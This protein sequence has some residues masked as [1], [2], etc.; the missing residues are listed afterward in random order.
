MGGPRGA[1]AHRKTAVQ[2]QSVDV[3][4]P[5]P[6]DLLGFLHALPSEIPSETTSHDATTEDVEPPKKRARVERIDAILIARDSFTISRPTQPEVSTTDPISRPNVHH[7]MKLHYNQN[8]HVL[9]LS[10]TPRSPYGAFKSEISIPGAKF[11]KELSLILDVLKR[12]RDDEGEEGALWVSIA[13]DLETKDSKDKLQLTLGL[14]WNSSTNIFRTPSQRA[15]SQQVLD[16]FFGCQTQ[17]LDT[18]DGKLLPQAF[19]DA[20][21][22]TEKGNT[23]MSITPPRLT[24]SL[25][26]FQRRALQWLLNREGVKWSGCANG[27]PVL[28][29]LPPPS[30]TGLP[31]SF[32]ATKDMT[33]QLAFVSNLYHV[34]TRDTAPFRTIE[35]TVKG[36]ILAEEMGL[37]KTVEMISLICTHTR[38]NLPGPSNGVAQNPRPS[39][40]TLIVTPS[41]LRDQW[42]GEFAKHAPDLRVMVYSGLR[43]FSGD[44]DDLVSELASQDVVVTTYDVLQSEI[45][46]TEKPPNRSMR[47]APKY[48]RPKSPLVHIS[49]WRVC[50]D[51]AQQIESGVSSAAKV[52]RLIPRVNAW[53][54]TG[55]PVK[56]DIKDLWGLL[57]FLHYEPFASSTAVWDMLI[58]SHKEFF[59]PLF[60]RIALRHTKRAVRD[61][62]TLPPQK[63]YV[64][65]IPFTA[66]EEEHYQA[67]F[68]ELTKE[69][70]FD[71]RGVL[72]QGRAGLDDPKT[73]EMMK[74]ALASLRLSILHPSLGPGLRRVGWKNRPLHT[75]EEMLETMIEQLESAIKVDQRTYLLEMIK[76]GQLLEDLESAIKLWQQ[77]I[78][79]VEVL[80]DECRKQVV[81]ALEKARQAG[82]DENL[83]ESEDDEDVNKSKTARQLS[84]YRRRLRW[85]LDVQHRAVF[86]MASAYYELKS[87][88]N[89]TAPDSNEFK[90]LEEKEV[91]GYATAKNIRKEMLQE[92]HT[93]VTSCISKLRGKAESQSFTVIPPIELPP[94][95]GIESG[96]IV[97]NFLIL[98]QTLEHQA[99]AIDQYREAVIQM[100]IRPLVDE[101]G[102]EDVTGDEYED[103]TKLQDELMAYTLA[104]RALVTDRQD[105]ISGLDNERTRHEVAIAEARAKNNEGHAPKLTL[106]LLAE[107]SKIKQ[108][109][110]LTSFRSI[111]ADLRDLAAR[112]RSNGGSDR[113][114]IELHIVEQHLRLTQ[115]QS[116]AQSKTAVGLL[117]E[118]DAFTAALNARVEYYRQLQSISDTLVPLDPESIVNRDTMILASLQVEQYRR[119]KVARDLPKHRYLVH[120]KE[121]GQKQEEECIICQSSF[122][123]GVLTV[124][125]HQFCK[126]CIRI[127]LRGRNTCPVCKTFLAAGMTYDITLKKQELKVH[128]EHH[129]NSREH[130]HGSHEAGSPSKRR[131]SGIY[132]EI[133]SQ[134]LQAIKNI[135]VGAPS[136]ATKVN[137]LA[138]HLLWLRA[139]D[140][141]AK[142]IIFSQ[143][144]RFLEILG[145]A[146]DE[147]RI[148]YTSF[149]QKNGITKFKEE[150]GIECFLM[151]ARAH[152]SGLNLINASHVFLCEPVLN[153]ALELQAIARVD[154]IGQVHPTTVWLYLI[155]GTVEESIYNLSVQ[156]R[157]KYIGKDSKGKSK[158][159]TDEITDEITDLSIEEANSMVVEQAS[160]SKLMNKDQSLG[161]AID[162]DDLWQCFFG[163]VAKQDTQPN[164]AVDERMNDP[165]VM[166]FLA[167]EAAEARRQGE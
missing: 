57:V 40:A 48:H 164:A 119:G 72:M 113:A 60:N 70:G 50:L 152:A 26:P 150:P 132:S 166:G 100:L 147:Y 114:R 121:A 5:F 3:K 107:R 125:G 97:N 96:R 24:S 62:L 21:F 151:D 15:L 115:D 36:G 159:S 95:S 2:V 112:L 1:K 157:L 122:T 93:K 137:T 25:F 74:H 134:K 92:T 131:K 31:L 142:S 39:G 120:L 71:E 143:F 153:T 6:A 75:V 10:S 18:A 42:V 123:L 103:S 104:L 28:E 84:E 27:E 47:N 88:E 144:P 35:T 33:G 91:S 130:P 133:D 55:T 19:Y 124:C 22:L 59:Q 49:W 53:G 64:I 89:K 86:F 81:D 23:D 63:R 43:G 82:S 109:I 34:M 102:N 105:A 44:E 163:H 135:D 117:K 78:D 141:G 65:T 146:F 101:E 154:R 110:R 41:T 99:K 162:K 138:K 128:Q 79:E 111:I 69:C 148:G 106:K 77:I 66:V 156:R 32:R 9:V 136:Y 80:V 29:P 83:E 108:S 11:T 73:I 87:D 16:V 30:T 37:G 14:N 139:Q 58:T 126:D 160:L 167:G 90:A 51:E 38:R 161:E 140:P 155:D 116:T 61:E 145:Q 67:Q 98:E 52:A 85:M 118:L 20:A 17:V 158:Q 8:H 76:R 45:H 127:W 4:A 54:V 56:G 13:V 12:S 149:R 68:T 94:F 46:Y 7:H 129:E 165:A